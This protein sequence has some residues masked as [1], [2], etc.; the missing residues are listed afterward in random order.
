MDTS[1]RV[2][3]SR[4]VPLA[5]ALFTAPWG[6]AAANA[7]YAWATRAGG[8]DETGA[9]TLALAAAHPGLYRLGSVAAMLGSL[10]MVPAALGAHRLLAGRS[11]RLGTTGA[12][13]MAGGYVCY[14]AIAFTGVIELAMAER[15]GP[16]PDYAAVLDRGQDDLTGLWVFLL[17][18]LGNLV[19]TL[20]L[21]AALLRSHRVPAWA[22][23]AVL[24]WPPL[25]VAGLVAGSEWFEVAGGVLQ[26]VGLGAAGIR[27][28]NATG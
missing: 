9:Q 8:G 21:G 3:A 18:V 6:L 11:P 17:F 19:G 2:A 4:S 26:A 23:V 22:A 24:A 1:V 12:V 13:L 10:L 16:V 28:L 5:L 27:L 14:F 15:G 7:A 20:L 25:H